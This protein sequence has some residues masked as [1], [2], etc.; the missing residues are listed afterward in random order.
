M[1]MAMWIA[2]ICWNI[3]PEVASYSSYSYIATLASYLWQNISANY[4]VA[5]HIA[6]AISIGTI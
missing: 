4:T 1:A 6:I 2:I 5:I 3:L